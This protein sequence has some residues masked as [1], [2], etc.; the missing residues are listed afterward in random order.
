MRK[1][2]LCKSSFACGH[3]SI[4][5]MY[6]HAHQLASRLQE[7]GSGGQSKR[8][9][10]QDVRTVQ[11][12][13]L[14]CCDPFVHHACQPNIYVEE[15]LSYQTPYINSTVYYARTYVARLYFQVPI[16]A[17][18]LS[19][20]LAYKNTSNTDSIMKCPST[21]FVTFACGTFMQQDQ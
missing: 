2:T 3:N 5:P 9:N 8:S 18:G 13:T 7:P 21:A 14:Q 15:T 20:A 16:G 17:F 1:G 12:K 10:D 6:M 19:A 11:Q 4:W